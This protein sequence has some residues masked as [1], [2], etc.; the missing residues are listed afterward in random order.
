MLL[1]DQQVNTF[2]ANVGIVT[3]KEAVIPLQPTVPTAPL[4]L[5]GKF[6]YLQHKR[7]TNGQTPWS[8]ER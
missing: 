3:P 5:N 1:C 2:H 7:T 8:Q 6:L 4:K